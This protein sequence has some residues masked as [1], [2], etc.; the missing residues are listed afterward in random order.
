MIIRQIRYLVLG[1]AIGLMFSCGENADQNKDSR[2]PSDKAIE[3]NDKA[4]DI[5]FRV[6]IQQ[7]VDQESKSEL[8][9]AL[10]Y[11]NKAI[12]IQNDYSLAKMNKV[13]ILSKLGREKDAIKLLQ[14]MESTEPNYAEVIYMQGFLYERLGDTLKAQSIYREAIKAYNNRLER[15]SNSVEDKVEKIFVK[16][17]VDG[18]DEAYRDIQKLQ[19]KY[20]D[21]KFVNEMERILWTFNRNDYI[22]DI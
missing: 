22:N 18:K 21:N 4:V 7:E 5:L 17:F 11:I 10:K 9:I 12:E 6:S 20:P 14:E 3:Y 16:A 8:E 2:I 1:L 19:E 13:K 15:D